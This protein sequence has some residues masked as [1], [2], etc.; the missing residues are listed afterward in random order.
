MKPHT[1][2]IEEVENAGLGANQGP[3][4]ARFFGDAGTEYLKRYG[5]TV[6]HFAKIGKDSHRSPPSQEA[7][8]TLHSK[9]PR[10]TNIL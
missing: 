9:P 3:S 8:L 7:L 1:D 6:E 4:A 10:T 5:G 2:L